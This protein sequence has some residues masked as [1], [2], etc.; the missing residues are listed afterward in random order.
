MRAAAW[1]LLVG[2]AGLGCE[3]ASADNG[4]T[5]RLRLTGGR[6]ARLVTA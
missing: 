5:A 2:C 1:I 3:G 6:V 4:L